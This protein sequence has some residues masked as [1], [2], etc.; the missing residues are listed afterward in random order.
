MQLYAAA[1]YVVFFPNPRGSTG[2]GEEF[3]N[4]LYHNYP[5]EDYNDVMDGVDAVIDLGFVDADRLYV[6][7]GS[8]GGIMTAWMIG[9]NDRFKAAA[10]IKP[11]M[12]WYSKTLNADN[13]FYYYDV[14]IP[15]NAL[16]PPR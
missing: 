12:N 10:V 6:T 8:A 11:V 3:A 9:K 4:L 15:G 5:G 14:R 13:W 7:G 16:D 1:G 2:Y